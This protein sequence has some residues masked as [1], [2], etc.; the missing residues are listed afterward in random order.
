M[1][2]I[3]APISYLRTF[4]WRR[5]YIWI[6]AL[7]ARTGM[8]RVMSTVILVAFIIMTKLLQCSV[9]AIEVITFVA[10]VFSIR[11][12]LVDFFYLRTT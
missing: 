2:I 11:N 7:I 5:S 12:F 6:V 4:L 9:Q 3:D 8:R 1:T 10:G